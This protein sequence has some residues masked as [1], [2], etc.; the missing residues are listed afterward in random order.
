MA[1]SFIASADSH[2]I[3]P[4][5]LWTKALG[6][7]YG[8]RVPH[9]HIGEVRG[10]PGDYVFTGMEYIKVGDLRQEGAGNTEDSTAPI[11][12]E[13][14]PPELAEKVTRSNSDPA[15]RLELMDFDSVNAE[16]IQG[17]NMLLAMRVR[18]VALI[19]DCA[20]VFNDYCAEYCS[21]HPARLLGTAMIP[22][23]DV[24]WAINELDRVAKKGMRSAIINTDLPKEFEPYRSPKYDR[25]WAAACELDFPLVLH[26]GTGRTQDPFTLITPEEKGD[27]PGLFLDIFDDGRRAVAQEFIFGGVFDKFE[28][29]KIILGEYELSWFPYYA[30]RLRQMQ[31]A[32][33]FAMGVKRVKKLVDQYLR[34]NVFTGFTD[35]AYFS[36]GYDVAG[37][38]NILWG[39]DYP[40]P[41]NTF[42]NTV[43]ILDRIFSDVPE[44]VKAKAAGL[45]MARLFKLDVKVPAAAPVPAE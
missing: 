5:D 2:I 6:K 44:R 25:L 43:K 15:V 14:F 45:N 32:L 27:V 24:E 1:L 35:D 12:T 30:F 11:A 8:D 33:G 21:Q 36:R 31:G 19:N 17:T 16:I 23:Y 42:P 41:R 40:H 22:T 3:E 18:D 37:E 9:R 7:K 29:L 28:K 38:D 4:Y 34:N 26:L 13:D 10:V 20:K 39:S